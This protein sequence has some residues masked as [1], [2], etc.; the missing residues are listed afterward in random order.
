MKFRVGLSFVDSVVDR[1]VLTQI[2][3][4]CS[5]LILR[6]SVEGMNFVI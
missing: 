5:R 4:L 1:D 2:G 3:M 6:L